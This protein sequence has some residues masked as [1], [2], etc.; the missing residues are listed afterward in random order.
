MYVHMDLFIII[1]F[2]YPSYKKELIH[3]YVRTYICNVYLE[4]Y[5]TSII[6]QVTTTAY[7]KADFTLV[8]LASD[9]WTGEIWHFVSVVVYRTTVQ[10]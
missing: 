7:I 1:K 2:V 9:S 6:L 8:M 4:Y 10:K 3:T 5:Y